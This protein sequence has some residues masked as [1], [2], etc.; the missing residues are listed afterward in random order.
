MLMPL[1]AAQQMTK[2]LNK[3]PYFVNK[4]K[5]APQFRHFQMSIAAF[6]SSFGMLN[7]KHNKA[8][9]II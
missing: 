3:K 4:K 9:L 1:I 5:K 8:Y 6:A 7:L 2:T